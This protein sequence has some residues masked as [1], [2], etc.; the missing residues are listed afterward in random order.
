MPGGNVGPAGGGTARPP[1]ATK[2]PVSKG[3]G[4]AGSKAKSAPNKV[5]FKAGAFKGLNMTAA[6]KQSYKQNVRQGLR[7]TGSVNLGSK[8]NKA[9]VAVRVSNKG[10][11]GGGG[12]KKA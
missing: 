3:G 4:G 8:V 1:A 11:T 2:P 7:K 5:Q 12:A 6:Q 10:K 9:K